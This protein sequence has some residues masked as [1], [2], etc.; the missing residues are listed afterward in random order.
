MR[1]IN[2]VNWIAAVNEPN[3]SKTMFF[4]LRSKKW[5]VENIYEKAESDV[6]WSKMAVNILRVAQ[7]LEMCYIKIHFVPLL[8]RFKSFLLSPWILM[9]CT[10]DDQ[11]VWKVLNFNWILCDLTKPKERK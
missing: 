4:F 10:D 1:Q 6:V 3:N 7:V 9:T 11:I 8:K 2:A 5:A